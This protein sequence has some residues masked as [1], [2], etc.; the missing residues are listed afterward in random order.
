MKSWIFWACTFATACLGMY[1][2][3][4]KF[5]VGQK[6]QI[7]LSSVPTVPANPATRIIP[8]DAQVFD[9]DAFEAEP[10]TIAKL[11]AQGKIVLCYFSAGT[12]EEWRPD[13]AQF[14]AADKGPV[15]PEW[16]G[17]QWLKLT[18]QNVRSIMA[19]RVQMCA[20]KGCDAI[21][22]DNTDG[23]NNPEGMQTVSRQEA[24]DY[25]K[26]LSGVVTANNMT[27]GL[28][29]SQGIIDDVKDVVTFAVNE[30]CAYFS[31]CYL[32][33][34]FLASGKPVYHIEYPDL[35]PNSTVRTHDCEPTPSILPSGLST[36]MKSKDLDGRVYYCDG[37]FVTTNT[38]P[39]DPNVPPPHPKSTVR[40]SS[41]RTSS[42]YS[43]TQRPTSTKGTSTRSSTT[44][45]PPSSST[46]RIPSTTQTFS[47]R[48]TSTAA[49]SQSGN[50][51]GFGLHMQIF[52]RLLF[53][54]SMMRSRFLFV[55][56][57][58]VGKVIAFGEGVRMRAQNENDTF[59]FP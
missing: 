43:S 37:S 38:K 40:P 35:P 21:D 17:E 25:I 19:T 15:L 41:T 2:N 33:D 45:R 26:W 56:T 27:M 24:I 13:K 14:Q 23:Y 7:I 5:Q 30:Q 46:T 32:Y 31:E 36:V 28:K 9:I 12:Y 20:T 53:P 16:K 42:T 18:S 59:A 48:T 11:Q 6:F 47:T 10:T 39:G 51:N 55:F 54:M 22:P 49:P 58:M 3:S 8:S 50:P 57:G 44:T 1:D 52:E 4:I 34:N 29:N